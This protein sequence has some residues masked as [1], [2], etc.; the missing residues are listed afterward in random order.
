MSPNTESKKLELSLLVISSILILLGLYFLWLIKTPSNFDVNKTYE[1][2]RGMSISDAAQYFKKESA[3]KSSF[4]FKLLVKIESPSKGVVAGKYDFKDRPSFFEIVYN[5]TNSGYGDH[6]LKVTIPEGL[7]NKEIADILDKKIED[8]D[9]EA[10]M[11]LSDNKQ[12]YLFPDT[13]FF[14]YETTAKEV[15]T[16]FRENFERRMSLIDKDVKESGHALDQIITMASIL[17]REANDKESRRIISG[18]LWKRLT[19]GMPLQVDATLFYLL[20]KRSDELS[21][22]DL[23][24]A[25]PYNTYT[26]QGLPPSPIA[27]PGLDTIM[28]AIYPELTN[29]TYYLS[30]E[31]G[32]M[33][34][35]KTFEEHKANKSKYLR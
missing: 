28:A 23:K 16:A 26:N 3:I 10:F 7:T 32:N 14:S 24:F 27:N 22:D 5:V 18:I 20:G 4:L 35:A 12:G 17:E 30:D 13:Y 19:D 1:I 31:D 25:S 33:H 34:Y 6:V 15:Y 11:N 8:F 9:K 29:Y 2:K 21:I